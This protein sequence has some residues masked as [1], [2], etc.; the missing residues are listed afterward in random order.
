MPNEKFDPV[1][2]PMSEEE[3]ARRLAE[4]EENRKL[5]QAAYDASK[6]TSEAAHKPQAE[7]GNEL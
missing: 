7:T 3:K 2:I 6:R 1:A 5:Q 4:L